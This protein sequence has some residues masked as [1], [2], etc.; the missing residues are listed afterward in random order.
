MATAD[1]VLNLASIQFLKNVPMAVLTVTTVSAGN[2]NMASG[3]FVAINFDTS[4]EDNYSGH[5]TV[6]NNSRYTA[7]VAGWYWVRGCASFAVPNNTGNRGVQLYVNGSATAYAFAILQAATT[8]N[9]GGYEVNSPVFLNVGDYVEVR[10]FQS[11][12]G[13]LSLNA[14]GNNM[15]LYWMHS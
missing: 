11:S 10:A 8:A 1:E 4:L 3:S 12:G 7:Q 14:A 6:T 5:S 2:T 15:S 9:F 13:T